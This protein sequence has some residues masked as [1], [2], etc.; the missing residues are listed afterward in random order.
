MADGGLGGS[1]LYLPCFKQLLA[2]R[3][4]AVVLSKGARKCLEI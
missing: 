3:T 2:M 4:V 1:F